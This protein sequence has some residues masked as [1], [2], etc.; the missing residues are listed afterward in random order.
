VFRAIATDRKTVTLLRRLGLLAI[1]ALALATPAD[2]RGPSLQGTPNERAVLAAMNEV[3]AERGL[4]PL[5]FAPALWRAAREHSRDMGERD[6]FSHSTLASGQSFDERVLR[7]QDR[8]D[9]RW[10][11]ETIGWGSGTLADPDEMVKMWMESPPHRRTIL[12]PR[13]RMVGVGTWTGTFQG[14]DGVRVFT[15][16]FAG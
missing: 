15:A 7:F 14:Y 12:D 5:R 8:N 1:I 2:A 6:Y 16:D 3:R 11:G 13:F 10:L 9:V 4:A